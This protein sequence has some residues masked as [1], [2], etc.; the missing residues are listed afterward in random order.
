LAWRKKANSTRIYGRSRHLLAHYL[1][2][3]NAVSDK[4][5][6]PIYTLRLPGSRIYVVNSTAL[7]SAVQ[8]QSR[9]LD[10]APVKT[11]AAINVM[12]ATPAAKEI[13]HRESE[14]FGTFAYANSFDKAI[15]PAL[16]PGFN[17][18]A[19]NRLSVQKVNGIFNRLGKQKSH[20]LNLYEWV[21][22][23]IAWATTEGVYGPQNPFR[24]HAILQ[25][26]W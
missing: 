15:H 20:T 1:H 4:Y 18:D 26:F 25:A 6:L 10:F 19:L 9:V 23:N 22:E 13:L 5:N 16:T 2:Q 12:A 17:L 7:I 3:L 14:E 8:R 11:K 21:R 24:D